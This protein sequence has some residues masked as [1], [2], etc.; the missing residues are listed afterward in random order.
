[1]KATIQDVLTAVNTFATNIEGELSAIKQD[2]SEIK[3]VM[4]TKDEL[5]QE[6]SL[7]QTDITGIRSTM[8]TK[9]ELKEELGTIQVKM[10]SKDYLDDKLS[11]LRGDL[12][13]QLHQQDSKVAK[14]VNLFKNI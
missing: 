4:V 14:V 8:V 9:A 10:V 13:L 11:D 3:S 2:I 6:I 7:L 1:M 5:K 12:N